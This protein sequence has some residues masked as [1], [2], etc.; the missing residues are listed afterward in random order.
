MNIDWYGAQ[1]VP[2][3]TP[4]VPGGTP[5]AT[6][7]LGA[8]TVTVA[9]GGAAGTF[10]AGDII[11]FAGHAT[12]YAVVSNVTL[13]GAGGGSV[14]ISPALTVAITSAAVTVKGAHAA[15]IVGHPR[16]LSFV[17]VPLALP[18]DTA[19]ANMAAALNWNGLS[20]RVVRAYDITSKKNIIS[21]DTLVGAK[22]TDPRMLVRFDG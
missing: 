1:A 14:A 8:T 21:F 12:T 2:S 13:S 15:N 19:G 10:K 6:G 7:A 11:T 9:S 22:V 20:I 5:T 18:M 17:S 4:G 16:G 3:H